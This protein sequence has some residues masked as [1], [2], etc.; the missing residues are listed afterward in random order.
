LMDRSMGLPIIN[1]LT[2]YPEDII[3]GTDFNCNT[4]AVRKHFSF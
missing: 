1:G 3:P 4:L 2:E